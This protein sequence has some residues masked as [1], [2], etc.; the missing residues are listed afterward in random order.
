[1][2]VNGYRIVLDP[3]LST[4]KQVRFPRSK[5][6]RIRRK[7]EKRPFNY[8]NVADKTIYVMEE[9]KKMIMH[10]ATWAVFKKEVG[11]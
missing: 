2:V 10:P 7:W 3:L 4:K 9:W 5:S 1:M 8:T 6:G 11:L